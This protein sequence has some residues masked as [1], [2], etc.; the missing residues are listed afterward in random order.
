[1]KTPGFI[2]KN[3]TIFPLQI[4]LNQL[5][6]LYFGVIQPGESFIRDTGAVWFTIRAAI[7]LDESKQI[8]T[9]NAVWPILTISGT[10]LASAITAGA[11]AYAAGP[12]IAA[13]GIAGVS[14]VSSVGTASALATAT[15]ASALVG[16]GFSAGASLVIGGVV[17]GGIA[18]S[19]LSATAKA[20]L[21]EIFKDENASVSEAGCYA[22][23]AWPFRGQVKP[24]RITGGPTFRK[25]EGEDKVEIVAAPMSI[26]R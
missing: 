4:S 19:A 23:F 26:S 10:V 15:A 22:G 25:V 11:A 20:A 2:I 18:G 8:T 16:A 7:I 17:V 14:G 12:S 24:W 1:M 6:P 13:A 9:A 21:E 5:S 3:E